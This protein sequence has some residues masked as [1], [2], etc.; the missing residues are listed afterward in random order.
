MGEERWQKFME[1]MEQLCP[2]SVRINKG[3]IIHNS[4]F[5]IHNYAQA[6]SEAII[7]VL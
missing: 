6:I 2:N 4:Q 5:I 3:K 1:G 7:E